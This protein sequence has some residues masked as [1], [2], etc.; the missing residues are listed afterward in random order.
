VNLSRRGL[1]CEPPRPDVA[2]ASNK[3]VAYML[4]SILLYIY[5]FVHT[6][7]PG[8]SS[9]TVALWH[10]R[11]VAARQWLRRKRHLR[12]GSICSCALK[13][14]LHTEHAKPTRHTNFSAAAMAE[15]VAQSPGS[16]SGLKSKASVSRG[17]AAASPAPPLLAAAA[18]AAPRLLPPTALRILL[19]HVCASC[20]GLNPYAFSS[21]TLQNKVTGV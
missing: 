14:R 1:G 11:F 3:F 2:L 16:S 13:H 18:A 6:G 20:T 8:T 7:N 21:G 12:R 17:P 19:M 4:L 9:A 15:R 10:L 5:L